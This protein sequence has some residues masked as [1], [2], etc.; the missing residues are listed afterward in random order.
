MFVLVSLVLLTLC[1]G[2]VIFLFWSVD[3]HRYLFWSG[4]FGISISKGV[5]I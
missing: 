5:I 2:Q 1:F 3:Y 4:Y